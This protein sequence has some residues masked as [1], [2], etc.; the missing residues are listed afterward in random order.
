MEQFYQRSREFKFSRVHY[1]PLMHFIK[2]KGIPVNEKEVEFE[3]LL[4]F[5]YEVFVKEAFQPI[6]QKYFPKK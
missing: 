3:M 6:F 4:R 2:Q 1:Y 5:R